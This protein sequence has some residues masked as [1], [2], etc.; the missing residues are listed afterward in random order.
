MASTNGEIVLPRKPFTDVHALVYLFHSWQ[1]ILEQETM[2]EALRP[3]E[4]IPP[5]LVP[6][7]SAA[8]AD[9]RAQ[10]E[11]AQA[12][13]DIALRFAVTPE[14]GDLMRWGAAR[15]T[16]IEGLL[17]DEALNPDWQR[18]LNLA[19]DFVGAALEQLDRVP[20][21]D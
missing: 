18:A 8:L 16:D 20:L 1:L 4:S 6:V 12:G 15:L 14:F 3:L 10:L 19:H 21:H 13:T 5:G 9:A 2:P 7:M 11:T 17:G